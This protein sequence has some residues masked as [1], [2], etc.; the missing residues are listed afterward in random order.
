MSKQFNY[1]VCRVWV[2]DKFIFLD[3]TEPFIPVDVLPERCLNGRG[4]LVSKKNQG[5][6]NISSKVKAKSIVSV[7]LAMDENS[8]LKGSVSYMHDGY[9]GQ[10]VRRKIKENGQDSYLKGISKGKN[11]NVE[12]STLENADKLEAAVKETHLL[13]IDEHASVAGDVIYLDPFIASK[14]SEN[15]FR[16]EDRKYP[17]DFGTLQ[18]KTYMCKITIPAGYVVDEVPQ[19]KVLMLPG[20]GGKFMF[21]VT[22]MGNSVS[23]TN[24]V[25]IN[26]TLFSSD[27][28]PGLRE[29]YNQII[30][31][32]SEQIVLK[33]KQ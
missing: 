15:P 24:T 25:Q 8:S 30:A 22:Q 21:N 23:I 19:S 2:G 32:Q 6:V 29:F 11:W 9:E 7:D 1:V 16:S 17:V 31:K 4:L 26:K 12:T 28:Y 3:G 10:S 27:E 5:W 18:E 33:K 20:N 13:T 14:L